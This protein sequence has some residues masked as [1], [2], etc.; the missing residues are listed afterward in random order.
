MVVSSTSKPLSEHFDPKVLA[1]LHSLDLKARYVVEGFLSGIHQSPFHGFSV[2]FSEYRDYQPGDDLRYIDWRVYA[3][4]DRLCV[5]RFIAETNTRFY[6]LCDT[7]ASMAYRGREAW[8][9]KLECAQVLGAA[10]ALL[11]LR[12]N[13]AVGLLSMREDGVTPRFMRPSQKMHQ[14]GRILRQMERLRPEGGERLPALLDHAARLVHR[15]SVILILSDFLEPAETIEVGLRQIRFLGHECMIFQVL[16]RDEVEFPFEDAAVFEDLETSDR[17]RVLPGAARPRYL[18]RFNTFMAAH[19][20]MFR[21]LEMPHSVF[22]TDD[23]PWQLLAKFL[24]DR[25]QLR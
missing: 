25:K 9:S 13:D 21:T 8:G 20:E 1:L 12:Q 24:L 7:S 23:D 3:R 18:E 17:R 16:D 6:V 4:T 2:E 11:M 19:R 14:F 15:R 10:L 22:R 5:K